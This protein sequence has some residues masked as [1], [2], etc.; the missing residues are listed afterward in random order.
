MTSHLKIFFTNRNSLAVGI[1]FF[2][3]GFLFGNWA[4]LIPF[5]KSNYQIDDAI[6]G[7]ML[8]CLPLGAMTFN[9][10]AA[11]MIQKFGMQRMTV[12]G[13]FLLSTAYALPLSLPYIFIVPIGLVTVGVCMTTLNIAANTM[14]TSLEQTERINIMSTCH[15]MFSVGLMTGSLMRSV[16]LLIGLS[17]RNHMFLM[18][19]IGII[20]ALI[21]A[22]TILQIKS[23]PVVQN[24][25][26]EKFKLILPKGALMVIIIISICINVTEGSMTDWASL[27]MKEIVETSPYFV[28]WGLFGYSSF[29]ALGRFFG[30]GII[31]VY[32]KNK[33]LTYGAIVACVGLL[34]MI[35]FPYTWTAIFGFALIGLGVSCGAPILYAA[36]ARYPGMPNA[37]GLA[38]MNTFAMGGFLLG[39]VVI[40]FISDLTSLP[41]A[42]G[43]VAVLGMLWFWK[44]KDADLF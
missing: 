28:G 15:G 11:M 30:D 36:A 2:L 1:A 29:M 33:I 18:C 16:T 25:A 35:I 38:I 6:L 4:T 39:P 42:F 27:Y 24:E 22:K 17:E 8:L 34:T 7:L 26:P 37:G 44:A 23:M 43:F 19:S 13:M 21:V 40:G 5:V 14:A 41:V 32:G 3:L 31:P 10:F 20:L 9:P 12:I